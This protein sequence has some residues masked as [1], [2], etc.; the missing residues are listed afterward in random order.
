MSD[1][2]FALRGAE[3]KAAIKVARK[4]SMGFAFSPGKTPDTHFFAMDRKRTGA[5][6]GK[7][8]KQEGDDSKVS[9]GTCT[10]EDKAFVLTCDRFAP[11]LA[12]RLR[13]FLQNGIRRT[14][15]RRQT[16]DCKRARAGCRQAG[17][18]SRA[19]AGIG[20][21]SGFRCGWQDHG[22]D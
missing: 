10:I 4:M 9:F 17:L 18:S 1:A 7:I 19:S 21:S 12:K 15:S 2:D 16:E 3:L 11:G 14:H 5:Y 22:P 20:E 6:L 13:R 8:A